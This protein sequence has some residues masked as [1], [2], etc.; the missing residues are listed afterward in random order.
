MY[1]NCVC[2]HVGAQA[3]VCVWRPEVRDSDRLATEPQKSF[4]CLNT[5]IIDTYLWFFFFLIYMGVRDLNSGP[6]CYIKIT[7]PAE[8]P[9]SLE[10]FWN[11]MCRSTYAF[12]C[13][14]HQILWSWSFR[15]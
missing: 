14:G 11:Y 10:L 12:R 4:I 15:Q 8:P 3:P 7:L 1:W 2:V 9:P 6:H 5:G 13:L